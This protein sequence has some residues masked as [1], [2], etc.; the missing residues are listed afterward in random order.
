MILLLLQIFYGRYMFFSYSRMTVL[1]CFSAGNPWLWAPSEM[2]TG[3]YE[4]SF[5]CLQMP[6][7]PDTINCEMPGL[8]DPSC[9]KCPGF[10]RGRDA[11][12][13]NWLAH[14]SF[15]WPDPNNNKEG[16]DVN[17]LP[18]TW[19]ANRLLHAAYDRHLAS[20]SITCS[21]DLGSFPAVMAFTYL[22]IIQ[23]LLLVTGKRTG[24]WSDPCLVNQ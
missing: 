8:Q 21:A 9:N 16:G 6:E 3:C 24:Q 14:N 23:V 19:A 18:M 15:P 22:V 13:W 7:G 10:A 11:R 20:L 4:T 5:Y 17:Y 2:T 1:D 12:G